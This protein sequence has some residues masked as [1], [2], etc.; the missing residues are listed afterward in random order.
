M[1]RQFFDGFCRAIYLGVDSNHG[2]NNNVEL[3]TSEPVEGVFFAHIE[4]ATGYR[5]KRGEIESE[6]K[7]EAIAYEGKEQVFLDIL[8]ER[9]EEAWNINWEDN[10]L[11]YGDAMTKGC[12]D[13][14]A[15][16]DNFNN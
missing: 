11:D 8:T 13:Y 10:N 15:A 5:K 6:T 7:A 1:N 4:Y 12:D 2:A 9:L 16:K 14:H 3:T